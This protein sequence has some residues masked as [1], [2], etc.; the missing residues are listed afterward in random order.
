MCIRDSPNRVQVATRRSK[1]DHSLTKI[2]FINS[3]ASS[4]TLMKL[5]SF[6]YAIKVLNPSAIL[7]RRLSSRS[8]NSFLL[9][10]QCAMLLF[11]S[12]STPIEHGSS[13]PI[14]LATGSMKEPTER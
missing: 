12:C 6:Q 4:P 8:L 13:W 2:S 5:S 7:S 10:T 11:R 9:P 3:P 14:V 1:R